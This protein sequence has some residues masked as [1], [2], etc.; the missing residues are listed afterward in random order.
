M[1]IQQAS[2][3][4]AAVYSNNQSLCDNKLWTCCTNLV[5]S[6]DKMIVLT[7]ES[8]FSKGKQQITKHITMRYEDI[9]EIIEKLMKSKVTVGSTSFGGRN[10]SQRTELHEA[11]IKEKACP[12]II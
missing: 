11:L 7:N 1:Q 12:E 3:Y 10:K 9:V 6:E 5:N 4:Q 2:E 8:N